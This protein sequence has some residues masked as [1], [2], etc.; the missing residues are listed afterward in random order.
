MLPIKIQY[1]H[2]KSIF[3]QQIFI[4]SFDEFST[5]KNAHTKTTNIDHFSSVTK[6]KA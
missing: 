4:C 1:E 3:L 6:Y 2:W 5:D